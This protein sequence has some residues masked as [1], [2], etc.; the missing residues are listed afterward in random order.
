MINYPVTTSDGFWTEPQSRAEVQVGAVELRLDQST[1]ADV[2]RLDDAATRLRVDRGTIKVHVIAMPPG[3][4]AVLTPLGQADLLTDGSYHIEAAEPGPDNAPANQM[5]V[6]VLQGH[7]C[8]AGPHSAL[9]VDVGESAV[10]GGNPPTFQLAEADA[11][12]FDDWALECERREIQPTAT[13]WYVLPTMTGYQD[14][15]QYG[16]WTSDPVYGSVWYPTGVPADWAPYRYGHWVW[17]QPWDWT[18]VDTAPW[19]FAPFH[20]WYHTGATYV[21]RVNYVRYSTHVT[22]NVVIN[23]YYNTAQTAQFRNA[24]AATVVSSHA[25]A[26]AAPV[27]KAVLHV[28]PQRLDHA[29]TMASLTHVQPTPAARAAVAHP[30]AARKPPPRCGPR[31]TRRRCCRPPI[32]GPNRMDLAPSRRSP[33]ASWSI[34][35]RRRPKPIPSRGGA[36]DR[37]A[38]AG[39]PAGRDA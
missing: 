6:S 9:T 2:L 24:R 17:A 23:N 21:R 16:Q 39:T 26:S 7:A 10:V 1:E 27:Q 5:I 3:G 20:P 35:R 19:G 14:L 29:R 32:A 11:T 38:S 8:V 13:V 22:N 33:R 28:D 18:W 36:A 15:D 34:H 30:E 37:H 25:F 12:S 31:H 4:V